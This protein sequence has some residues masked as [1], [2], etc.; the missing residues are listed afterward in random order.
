[1]TLWGRDPDELLRSSA[2]P[3]EGR[4]ERLRGKYQARF[5]RWCERT[6]EAIDRGEWLRVG[7]G[8]GL[9]ERGFLEREWRAE[10]AEILGEGILSP[11]S[12]EDACRLPDRSGYFGARREAEREAARA[13]A[14]RAVPEPAPDPDDGGPSP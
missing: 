3:A 2:V 13:A 6:C 5:D 9:F 10:A 1:M 4:L 7:R 14:M 12:L 8:L 11:R